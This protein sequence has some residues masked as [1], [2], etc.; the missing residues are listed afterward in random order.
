[1]KKVKLT[2]GNMHC[3]GCTEIVRHVL[4]NEDGVQACTV[5][6]DEHQA[7]VAIDPQRT[8]TEQLVRVLGKAG[9]PAELT[10]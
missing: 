9:Y 4:E 6:L 8:D 1:M 7:R 3:A 10:G 2:V 5:S